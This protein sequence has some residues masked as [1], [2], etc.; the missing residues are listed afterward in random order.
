MT[1][2]RQVAAVRVGAF[3]ILLF[4][5]TPNILYVGHWGPG[6]EREAHPHDSGASQ[7][8]H[9][10][11]CHGNANQCDAPAMVSVSWVTGESVPHAPPDALLVAMLP[12]F[13][14]GDL[15][16]TVAVIKPPPRASATI[17]A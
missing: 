17:A 7:S 4:A 15:E 12:P 10:E 3:V 9:A 16:T 1:G 2:H 8:G 13:V 14:P 5:L 11:H 6:A